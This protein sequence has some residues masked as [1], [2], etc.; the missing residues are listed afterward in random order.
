MTAAPGFPEATAAPEQRTRAPRRCA[1]GYTVTG[2]VID[3][4]RLVMPTL[5]DEGAVRD[6]RSAFLIRVRDRRAARWSA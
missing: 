4:A 5:P 3:H 6:R 2:S 1:R